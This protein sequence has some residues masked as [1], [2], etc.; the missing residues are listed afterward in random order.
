MLMITN[1]TTLKEETMLQRLILLAACL[2]ALAALGCA[3]SEVRFTQDEIKGFPVDIQE[4]IVKSEVAPGMTPQQVRYAWGSPSSGKVLGAVDGKPR[5]EW[6][7][8]SGLGVFKTRL[9]FVD[10]RVTSIVSSEPGRVK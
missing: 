5:E 2:A 8:S 4:R 6:T 1:R 7:Y 9:I 3:S 10:G